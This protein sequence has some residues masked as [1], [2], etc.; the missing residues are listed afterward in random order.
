MASD[1]NNL[2][3]IN[4]GEPFQLVKDA[5]QIEGGY[6]LSGFDDSLSLDLDEP[7]GKKR[8]ERRCHERFHLREDAFALIR[9]ISAAPLDIR[10]K[11]MGCIACAVFNARPAR[12]G[13][14]ENISMGGLMFQHVV[15]KKTQLNRTFVLDILAADCRFYLA[16]MPF[17]I[18]ADI[19]LPDDTPGFSFKMRQVR[20][21][22][23][24][25]S[26]NQQASLNEFLL[27]HGA[28]I[29]ELGVKY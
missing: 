19:V 25:L 6:D 29:G 23:Q 26:V 10:D 12:L 27:N 1:M 4:K 14:I 20:L 7:G 15:G 3:V 13:K 2:Y 28:E 24:N 11:S 18:K 17:E 21:Q 16:N 5:E 22:F 9:S 8:V